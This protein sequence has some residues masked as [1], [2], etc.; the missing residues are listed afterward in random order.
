MKKVF[1]SVATLVAAMS[2]TACSSDIF[3]DEYNVNDET[4]WNE[5]GEGYVSFRISMPADANASRAND[6][7]HNGLPQEFAVNDAYL[8]IFGGETTEAEA[9][10]AGA[11]Q[12]DLTGDWN[13]YPDTGAA[14]QPDYNITEDKTF[15]TKISR[16]GGSKAYAMVVLNSNGIFK[17]NGTELSINDAVF[18]GTIRDLQ[19]RVMNDLGGRYANNFYNNG[20]LMMN[21]PLSVHKG[22]DENPSTGGVKIETLAPIKR[23]NIKPTEQEAKDA[24]A[25]NIYV[26]RAVAKVTMHDHSEPQN[27]TEVDE[28]KGMTWKL[29]SWALDNTNTKSYLV[30]NTTNEEGNMGTWASYFTGDTSKEGVNKHRFVGEA[31]VNEN[32]QH[33][34]GKVEDNRYRTYFAQDP[35]YSLYGA[36]DFY[37]NLEAGN[38]SITTE[39]WRST[40]GDTHPVY[41]AENT[42]NVRQQI[43]GATTR[44][45]F[46]TTLNG[47]QTFYTTSEGTD[48]YYTGESVLTLAL[49]NYINS[50][51]VQGLKEDI[52][53]KEIHSE[54]V[55]AE[56]VKS[57]GHT[58]FQ[59]TWPENSIKF[60]TAKEIAEEHNRQ[61]FSSGAVWQDGVADY[62]DEG[63]RKIQVS[64]IN[65]A[66]RY[67]SKPEEW[68]TQNSEE[69]K[70]AVK[71][72]SNIPSYADATKNSTL[73]IYTYNN[74]V[75]YYEARIKHFGDDACPWSSWEAKAGVTVPTVT[76][77]AYPGTQEDA[78]RNYLGR[79][80]V[81]RNNWYD[82]NISQIKKIGYVNPPTLE[83]TSSN[84]DDE[85]DQF[86]AVDVN[87]LSWAKRTQDVVL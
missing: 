31:N 17:L 57:E 29:D 13:E 56:L 20:F 61:N 32:H 71:N 52:A 69:A 38:L 33:A 63:W 55:T 51:A 22:G 76:N 19:T 81:L 60:R 23:E 73:T 65:P 14:D 35:N 8:L 49:S 58:T 75:A 62:S 6:N 37:Y 28:G 67:E 79:W 86:I 24:V 25:A 70:A 10:L 18:N 72:M 27:L 84:T 54:D 26:E 3:N 34:T 87:V 66:Q 5:D 16:M 11:Y 30:R 9:K 2:F 83:K 44:V 40:Y 78:E 42:F 47:G 7:F 4:I 48:T 85:L 74:G 64:E 82:L 43:W 45:I 59:V 41:C 46:K 39:E 68:W 36:N 53:I 80:G 15:V 50:S 21:A 12:L 1:F 77:G